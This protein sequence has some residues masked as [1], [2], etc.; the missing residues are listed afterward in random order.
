M[1]IRAA[2]SE[3]AIADLQACNCGACGAVLLSRRHLEEY[4]ACR[5]LRDRFPGGLVAGRKRDGPR[6]MPLCK[7]CFADYLAWRQFHRER[8]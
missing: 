8:R 3:E 7:G 1:S 6:D 5:K 4:R 2:L